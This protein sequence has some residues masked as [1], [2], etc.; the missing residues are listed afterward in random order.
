MVGLLG[1]LLALVVF[2][3]LMYKNVGVYLGSLLA[4]II[5]CLANGLNYTDSITT[6]LSGIGGYFQGYFLMMLTG[7]VFGKVAEKSG[8][9]EVIGLWFVKILGKN[10][11][12][13]LL[14]FIGI[15]TMANISAFVCLFAMMPIALTV[16]KNN[17]WPRRLIPTLL[18]SGSLTLGV[19]I[20]GSIQV[21]NLIPGQA[22]GMGLTAGWAVGYMCS[23][24]ELV[25]LVVAIKWMIR[26]AQS[27]GE[28][29][30][31]KPGD[32]FASL[33]DGDDGK[34]RPSV[35]L[36]LIPFVFIVILANMTGKLGITIWQAI[37]I[38]I[39][40]EMILWHK[41]YNWKGFVADFREATPA[42]INITL[43][44]GVVYGFGL[45]LGG[46][47][48]FDFVKDA[49]VKIPGNPLISAAVATNVLAGLIGSASSAL[50]IVVPSLTE[51]YLAMGVAPQA[52]ARVFTITCVAMDSLP[53]NGAICSLLEACKEDHK[54]AY[55][56]L[57]PTTI[58][59]PLIG[60]V[61]AIILFS[62][63]PN[64]P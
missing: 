47:P 53:H 23:A 17:D 39:I 40:L 9:A 41:Y 46:T 1:L 36:A 13:A 32:T 37:A 43:T 31:A 63:F 54:S 55:L 20:P 58:I 28:H 24:I 57:V 27:R 52:L 62:I 51:T 29:F 19:T 4:L 12:L 18:I 15:C 2:A 16:Y 48:A 6:Y 7:A 10:A 60:T 5:V 64:L 22:V 38:G 26:R 8:A 14:L 3:I 33:A 59:V 35:P 42:G 49:V 50:N 30:E 11:I 45:V 44:M 61:A 56:S 34:A 21:H 25:C